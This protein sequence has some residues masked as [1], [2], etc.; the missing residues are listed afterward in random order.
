MRPLP[1]VLGVLALV[2]AYPAW[3]GD[4]GGSTKKDTAT[5]EAVFGAKDV[6]EHVADLRVVEWDDTL[7]VPKL[8]EVKRSGPNGAWVIPSRYDYPADTKDT[9]GKATANFLGVVKSRPVTDDPKKFE[10][11]GVIDPLDPDLSQ[12]SGRGKRV[13][14]QDVTGKTMVDVIIGKRAEQGDSMYFVRDAAEKQVYTAKL[15]PDLST[16]FVDYVEVDPLKVKSEDVRFLTVADYSIVTEADGGHPVMRSETPLVR[17]LDQ[18]WTTPAA[19]PADK[20]LAQGTASSIVSALTSIRLAGV[21]QFRLKSSADLGEMSTKGFYFSK[22]GEIDKTSPVLNIQGQNMAVIGAEGRLDIGSKDGLR[23]NLIFGNSSPEDDITVDAE[24]KADKKDDAKTDP[25]TDP[26][27]DDKKDGK[28]P[29]AAGHSRYMIVFV[30]YD[31]ATDE[32]AKKAAEDKAAKKP[33]DKPEE[34]KKKKPTGR[35]RA[36]K[37]QDR[38]IKYYYVI[39]DESFKQLR[40]A[41]DKLL[42]AKPPEPLAGNTGKTNSQWLAD[43]GKRP[44]VKTTASGLQYEIVSSGPEGGKKPA[45]SDRVQV[46]YKGTLVD[47]TEFDASKDAPAEFG[48]TQ[49][50]KGWTEALQLMKEGDKFKVYIKPELGYGEAG[51]PPKIPANALLVFEVELVKVMGGVEGA[52]VPAPAPAP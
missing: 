49:V 20:R 4:S 29:E 42:E 26:K 16:K 39:S 17:A 30:S 19:L 9:V 25:K 47:G 13:T 24:A 7:N 38:F 23:Y 12:K 33:D 43:N 10:E 34:P 28:K 27:A 50:I 2:T 15:K 6:P 37:A 5:V 14:M 51:S 36:A 40:P 45:P 11:L 3:K 48:V 32:D 22:P 44:E 1:I 8:I 18:T 35:E 41:L 21:R 52:P 46:R 31:E